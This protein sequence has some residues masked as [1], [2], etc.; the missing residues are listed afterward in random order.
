MMV[1]HEEQVGGALQGEFLGSLDAFEEN[2]RQAER[3][4]LRYSKQDAADG[5]RDIQIGALT[6]TVVTGISGLIG[7]VVM[8]ALLDDLIKGLIALQAGSAISAVL[9]PAGWIIGG[10][11]ALG[12]SA[13]LIT[14]RLP[15]ARAQAK[16]ELENQLVKLRGGFQE[17]LKEA[18]AKEF[19]IFRNQVYGSLL[20]VQQY[21]AR[22]RNEQSEAQTRITGLLDEIAQLQEQLENQ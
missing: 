3:A 18:A 16:K 14:R 21:L 12:G 22:L 13:F 9:G 5:L 7:G 17:A 1:R 19:T 6:D 20:P 15:K 8:V 10:A 2:V 11:A 4:L